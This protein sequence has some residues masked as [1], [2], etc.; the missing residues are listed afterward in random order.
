[1]EVPTILTTPATRRKVRALTGSAEAT[2]GTGTAAS[3][4]R[5]GFSTAEAA[6]CLDVAEDV[7]KTRLARA[8][9]S[10]RA[11]LLRSAELARK[12][13]FTFHAPR[14]D[15]VVDRVLIALDIPGRA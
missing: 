7:V 3:G 12:D 4:E 6:E 10:L 2:T 15:R 5:E 1:M 14:C 11:A 13:V 9:A 8:R